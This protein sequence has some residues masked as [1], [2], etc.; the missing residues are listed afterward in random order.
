MQLDGEWEGLGTGAAVQ[1]DERIKDHSALLWLTGT[2][3]SALCAVYSVHCS[4][5]TA[6]CAVC[7]VQTEERNKYSRLRKSKVVLIIIIC[8]LCTVLVS[9][10]KYR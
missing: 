2:V 5:C 3:C 7:S 6:Q 1:A 9:T 4:V 8:A 10:L